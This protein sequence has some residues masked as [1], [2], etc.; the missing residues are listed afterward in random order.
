MTGWIDRVAAARA[1]GWA[2]LDLLAVVD[3]GA[4]RE[5]VVRLLAAG[6]GEA[7]TLVEVAEGDRIASLTPSL[8]A[9][10]W[11]EREAAEMTGVVFVGHPDVR[12]LLL[13]GDEEQPPQRRTTPLPRR[14]EQ[15]WPGEHDPAGG[16]S[17]RPVVPP[18]VLGEWVT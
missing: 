18:G 7:R 13:T 1:D 12:P 2:V 3:R 8:P 4:H 6:S 16:R 15:S 10:D 17:R 9:A 5:V 11:Y 14:Q